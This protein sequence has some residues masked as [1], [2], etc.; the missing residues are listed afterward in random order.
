MGFE[1]RAMICSRCGRPIGAGET[2]CCH[3]HIGTIIVSSYLEVRRLLRDDEVVELFHIRC[4]SSATE[5]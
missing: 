5:R 3:T 4:W 1:E 2:L